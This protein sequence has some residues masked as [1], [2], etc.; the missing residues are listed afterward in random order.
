MEIILIIA[1]KSTLCS[2]IFHSIQVKKEK[3]GN[4]C[5]DCIK[6]CVATVTRKMDKFSVLHVHQI[7][8][9]KRLLFLKAIFFEIFAS[10]HLGI[11]IF[12]DR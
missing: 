1:D 6:W 4:K 10:D 7:V 8:E 11:K 3:K 5:V 9:K 2:S 12:F